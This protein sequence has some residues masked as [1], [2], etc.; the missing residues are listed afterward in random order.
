MCVRE[1]FYCERKGRKSIS[2]N[3]IGRKFYYYN[4]SV[5]ATWPLE[6]LQD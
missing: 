3:I 2:S 5:M 1:M 4:E 6:F